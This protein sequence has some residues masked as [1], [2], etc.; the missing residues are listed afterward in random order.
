MKKFEEFLTKIEPKTDENRR[1]S[2]GRERQNDRHRRTREIP[3][4]GR[5]AQPDQGVETA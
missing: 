5:R 4:V 3:P 1:K 2:R